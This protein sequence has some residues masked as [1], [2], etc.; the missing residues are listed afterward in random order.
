[1]KKVSLLLVAITAG[2]SSYAQQFSQ[3]LSDIYDL[4]VPAYNGYLLAGSGLT[5]IDLNG[6]VQWA[7]DYGFPVGARQLG[8]KSFVFYAGSPA[9]M[10]RTDSA[11]TVLWSKS[12]MNEPVSGVTVLAG[13]DLVLVG[14]QT[15]V[16]TDMNGNVLGSMQM[17]KSFGIELM[18]PSIVQYPDGDLLFIAASPT[19]SG[20]PIS[21]AALM[22]TDPT[23][24]IMRWQKL[25]QAV[26]FGNSGKAIVK[27]G[28]NVL[29]GGEVTEYPSTYSRFSLVKIDSSGTVIDALLA[30]HPAQAGTSVLTVIPDGPGYVLEGFEAN[31]SVL[32]RVNSSYNTSWVIATHFIPPSTILDLHAQSLIKCTDGG[33]L[34]LCFSPTSA[35]LLQKTNTVGNTGCEQISKTVNFAPHATTSYP[36]N[37][38]LG[39]ATVT[40]TANPVTASVLTIT[41][42][43]FCSNTITE[44]ELDA[45][46]SLY[47]NPAQTE[48]FVGFPEELESV[49]VFI[50]DVRMQLCETRTNV[51]SGASFNISHLPAGIYQ[52]VISSGTAQSVRRFVKQ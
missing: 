44:P 49:T 30:D 6:T 46:V 43:V 50:Y 7:V 40:A 4:V 17:P 51:P 22:K 16:K 31:G 39:S 26:P 18:E 48:V 25:I 47:P 1:M 5:R 15:I 23:G 34:S 3:T 10:I 11:G 28:Y 33:Y 27:E 8:D 37:F 29:I 52:M 12:Y 38:T 13:N 41:R 32:M 45:A 21:E 14:D 24:Q 36:A 2:L 42:N 19:F 35:S 20:G 9:R